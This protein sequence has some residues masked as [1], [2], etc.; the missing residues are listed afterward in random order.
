[1]SPEGGVLLV[2][3]G[4]VEDG[5][6]TQHGGEARCIQAAHVH[7]NAVSTSCLP[8]PA[9]VPHQVNGETQTFS[10]LLLI[11]SIYDLFLIPFDPFSWKGFTN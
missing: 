3:S 5:T 2:G 1:M 6:V 7:P 4:M 9:S 10:F 11:F 8:S